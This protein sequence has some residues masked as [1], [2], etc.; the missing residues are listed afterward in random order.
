LKCHQASEGFGGIIIRILV[1][2]AFLAISPRIREFS[3]EYAIGIGGFGDGQR[4]CDYSGWKVDA[5]SNQGSVTRRDLAIERTYVDLS[6]PFR[7]CLCG[8][9][10]AFVFQGG[11]LMVLVGAA[12]LQLQVV[13][14]GGEGKWD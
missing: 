9:A 3:G 1:P 12:L 7:V 11:V 10:A 8:I 5:A 2:L 13:S 14:M 4:F 6:S